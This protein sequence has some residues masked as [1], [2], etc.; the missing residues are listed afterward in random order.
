MRCGVLLTH[1]H[2]PFPP[3]PSLLAFVRCF[4]GRVKNCTCV[5]DSGFMS[6]AFLGEAW[7]GVMSEGS[8]DSCRLAGFNDAYNCLAQFFP[9]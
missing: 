7:H 2:P 4:L 3:S 8:F 5:S 1:F 9:P 6:F